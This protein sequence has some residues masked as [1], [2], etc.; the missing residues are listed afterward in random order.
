MDVSVMSGFLKFSA[1]D[2]LS[3]ELCRTR[4]GA[5]IK[6]PAS[7]SGC[8]GT[9]PSAASPLLADAP[10]HR[11]RRGFLHPTPWRS[12]CRLTPFFSNLRE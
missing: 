7:A 1:R 2:R 4:F 6:K 3:R 8:G 10:R 12:Q 9:G 11:R 5:A